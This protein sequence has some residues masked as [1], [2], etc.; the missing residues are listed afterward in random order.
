VEI[1]DG[2]HTYRRRRDG[3]GWCRFSAKECGLGEGILPESAKQKVHGD[4]DA[5]DDLGNYKAGQ[6]LRENKTYVDRGYTYHTDSQ[7]R[8]IK[9]E[10]NLRLKP[11]G[12]KRK[13]SRTQT[14]VGKLGHQPGNGKGYSPK[15][16]EG[17]HIIG[18][19]FE[20]SSNINNL[21][22]QN[23]NLNRGAWKRMENGW[24]EAIR[25]G[26][27]V[28]VTIELVFDGDG[29][30]PTAFKVTQVIDGKN[31]HLTFHN[32]PGG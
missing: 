21:V 31:K 32:T 6:R 24:A 18:D 2:G 26:K 10:G 16:D 30:R 9:V 23:A 19:R 29:I 25:Q 17:G 22:P 5:P 8:V 28:R 12:R 20:G 14:E 13:S 3:R 7:G 27:S 15:R 1:R 11:K 4:V